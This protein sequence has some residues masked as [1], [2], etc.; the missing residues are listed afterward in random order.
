[1]TIDRNQ[2]I[3]LL[4]E[5]NVKT[6][7]ANTNRNVETELLHLFQNNYK[8]MSN[9]TMHKSLEFILDLNSWQ[10]YGIHGSKRTEKKTHAATLSYKKGDVVF[11]KLG[12]LNIGDELSYDHMGV[13][14]GEFEKFIV[15]VP[16][17]TN[18]GQNYYG[19]MGKSV[20]HVDKGGTLDVGFQNN[21]TLVVHQIRS[22]HKNRII[23]DLN[24]SIKGT[25]LWKELEQKIASRFATE[26]IE[27]KDKLVRKLKNQTK[28]D[29]RI[30]RKKYEAQIELLQHQMMK[31]NERVVELEKELSLKQVAPTKE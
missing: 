27:E 1:M 10:E 4:N 8:M 19:E 12:T 26:F 9:Q 25:P 5:P 22:V 28:S 31:A 6:A 15:M 14:I 17:T 3:S 30:Q 21:S 23:R 18:R 16:I 2:V 29:L 20:I 7:L 24:F 11:V 13:V